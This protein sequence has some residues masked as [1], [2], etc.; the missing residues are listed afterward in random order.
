MLPRL[1][2]V[3]LEPSLGLSALCFVG[4]T[5][6]YRK[7][8]GLSY[9]SRSNPE[10]LR[11]M[12]QMSQMMNGGAGGGF[13]GFG[14]G[15]A[16]N[17]PAPGMPTAGA[18]GAAPVTGATVTPGATGAAPNPFAMWGGGAGA[19]AGVGAGGAQ[20]PLQALQQMQALQNM[21][22][23][24]Q[25]AGA[26][27]GAAGGVGSPGA[28]GMP[29]LGAFGGWGG[30]GGFGAPAAPTDTRP[31]E[32]RFQVQLEQLQGMGFLNAAQ[33]VRALLA[34]GGNVHAAIEYILGGGGL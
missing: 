2:H 1:F 32:E 26:G 6:S 9:H 24:M 11:A 22:G 16:A 3:P 8:N 18:E 4:F 17:F 27:A 12:M 19:G 33:N 21:F 20:N 28:G 14:G 7:T 29:N 5:L 31:P 34:T 25:G 10:Q 13:G 15:G 23:G 30:A